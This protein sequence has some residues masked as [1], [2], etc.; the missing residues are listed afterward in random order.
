[1]LQR[2]STL[3]QSGFMSLYQ[4]E[5]II[6]GGD[7]FP[8]DRFTVTEAIDRKRIKRSV[9]YWDKAGTKGGGAYTAGV[10]MHELDTK[11]F[12]IEDVR[13]GQWSVSERERMIKLTAEVDKSAYKSMQIWVEQEPGS[14]GKESAESTI[15]N[16]AGHAI[17]KD[18]VRGDKET[19]AEPYAVQVQNGNVILRAAEWNMTFIDEHETFPNGKFK[20][21]VDASAGAF[22][23][24]NLSTG[25]YDKSLSWVR[26]L[27]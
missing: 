24:L 5:P 11:D 16:L 27:R 4:G 23:K 18:P 3:T 7:L 15:K 1:L 17:Y 14:G 20:D 25:S 21:Q 2:K 12:Y 9:R 22:S 10:L 8:I 13:R 19:R 6:S 26:G